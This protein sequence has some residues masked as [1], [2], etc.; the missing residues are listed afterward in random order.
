MNQN[1]SLLRFIK[2]YFNF[3]YSTE[4]AKVV[5]IGAVK[6]LDE[7]DTKKKTKPASLQLLRF[8]IGLIVTYTMT[9]LII[10]S[11]IGI[12]I[13][14]CFFPNREIP[15]ILHDT[16]IALLGYFGGTFMAFIKTTEK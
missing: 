6:S 16:F 3:L 9:F 13:Y 14:S 7:K 2:D 15:L 1:S 8:K 5:R 11:F 4:L 10:I 12:I